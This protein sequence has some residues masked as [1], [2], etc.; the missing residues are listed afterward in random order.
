MTEARQGYGSSKE[1]GNQS[2]TTR[3][4]L[5]KAE[6]FALISAEVTDAE[7]DNYLEHSHCYAE[8]QTTEIAYRSNR[9]QNRADCKWRKMRRTAAISRER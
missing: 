2:K 7:R 6:E 4:E 1:P 8:S 5:G 3:H 9:P